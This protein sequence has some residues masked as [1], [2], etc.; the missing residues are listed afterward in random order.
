[1]SLFAL[2][3]YFVLLIIVIQLFGYSAANVEYNSVSQCQQLRH[4]RHWIP[5]KM[6]LVPKVVSVAL[7][8]ARGNRRYRIIAV[9]KSLNAAAL[10]TW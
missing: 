3:S 7:R 1:M 10:K 9:K 8:V 6:L 4:I 2:V 5:Q